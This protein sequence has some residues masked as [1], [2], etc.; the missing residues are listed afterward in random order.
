MSASPPLSERGGVGRADTAYNLVGFEDGYNCR[1][2]IG[3]ED[4]IRE[5]SVEPT[6]GHRQW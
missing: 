2:S 3:G 5:P 1:A 4:G 6:L